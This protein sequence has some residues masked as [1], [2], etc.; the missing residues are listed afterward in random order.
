MREIVFYR[1]NDGHS[2]I[3]EFLDSLSSKEAKKVAWV[4]KLIEV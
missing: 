1:K 3:E 4:L 2:P